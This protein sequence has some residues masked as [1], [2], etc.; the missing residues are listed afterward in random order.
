MTV[1]ETIDPNSSLWAWMAFDLWFYRTQRG[2][3]LAQTAKIVNVARGTV[4]NWEAGRLRPRDTY[5]KTLDRAW[6]TGGHFERLHMYACSGHD[7]DWR[8]QYVQ[9]EAAADVIKMYHG[10]SVPVLAQTEPYARAIVKAAGRS[11]DV[12]NE[13]KSRMK[14]QGVLKRRNPPYLWLLLDQEVLENVVGDRDVMAGQ[15]HFLLELAEVDRVCVRV[16]PRGAGWHPGH[17]GHFQVATVGGKGVSYAVAQL[18]GRLIDAGDESAVL[19]VRF[20][21]IGA[22][23]LPREDSKALIQETLG[24]YE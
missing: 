17:D 19:E 15:L 6:N 7:P 9:Y 20:D 14:R 10:K 24:R 1:R 11:G 12:E 5:L 3:S 22:I 23:A 4:S 18:A 16:V 13:A 21:E 2:L 8:K